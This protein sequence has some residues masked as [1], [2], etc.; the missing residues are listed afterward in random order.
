MG[1]L[2]PNNVERGWQMTSFK[3]RD[4]KKNVQ[5]LLKQSLNALLKGVVGGGGGGGK[6]M[7]KPFPRASSVRKGK[8]LYHMSFLPFFFIDFK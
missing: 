5:C 3:I 4:N 6:R 1:T 8:C 7:L 2:I